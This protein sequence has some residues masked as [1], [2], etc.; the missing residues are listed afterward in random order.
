MEADRFNFEQLISSIKQAH[1]QLREQAEGPLKAYLEELDLEAEGIESSEDLLKH[2]EQVAE[3][4][5]FTMEQVRKAMMDS[6]ETPLEVDRLY[7][8]LL[9]SSDGM[10]REILESLNLREEGIY[11]VEELIDLISRELEERGLSKKERKQILNELFGEA[12]GG[13][14]SSRDRSAWPVLVLLAVAGAGIV[15]FII[16]WWRRREKEGKQRE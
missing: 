8:E 6:L 11:T 7:E 9:Q 16:A 2:L 10:V 14:E 15:W 5:G 13:S 12:Y 3:A 4:E 1:E